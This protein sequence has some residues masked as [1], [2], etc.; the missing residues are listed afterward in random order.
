MGNSG[1]AKYGPVRGKRGKNRAN[2][3]KTM[4]V[5]NLKFF[6]KILECILKANGE[7]LRVS[8]QRTM[9]IEAL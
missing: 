7:P 3:V 8:E 2:L 9:M 4:K 1:F 5:K 6:L